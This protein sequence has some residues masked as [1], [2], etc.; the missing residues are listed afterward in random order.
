MNY[1]EFKE[2]N[3]PAL[4]K[5]MRQIKDVYV[6]MRD[7]K[8]LCVDIYLPDRDDRYPALLSFSLHNKELQ[9]SELCDTI[10]PQPAWSHFWYGNVEAGDTKYLVS[11]GY[12][13]V[14]A[15]AR[16]NGKSDS[17]TMFDAEMDHYD[18]IEWMAQQEWCDGNIGMLGLSA[19]AVNQLTAASEQPPHLKAIFPYDPGWCYG[20]FREMHLGGIINMLAY[21]LEHLSVAH[22]SVGQPP[23]LDE[24][25]EALWQKAM[26]NPDYMMYANIYNLLCQKGEYNPFG[27]LFQDLLYPYE[28]EG[29]MEMAQAKIDKIKIPVYTGSGQYAIDYHFHWQ[30]AQN[31]FKAL[32]NIP[33]KLQLGGPAHNERPFHSFHNEILKWYDYWLKG[34]DTGVMDEPPVRYWVT[35]ENKWRY[36][37]NWP[38]PETQWTKYYLHS[39]ERLRTDKIDSY[40]RDGYKEPDAFVQMSPTMT[41]EISLLRYMTEPLAEDTMIAGPISLNFFAALDSDDTTWIVTLKD[42]GPDYSDRT[43]REGERE[44]KE[45]PEKV[46]THGYL[47]ASMRE[48][49]KELS[50][51]EKPWHKLTKEAQKMVVPGEINEYN[52]EIMSVCHMFKSGHRISIEIACLDLP[53]GVAGATNVECIPYHICQNKT[54]YHKI[55]RDGKH[56]SHLLLPII[57]IKK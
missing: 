42:L 44:Q 43:G 47:R 49:D 36:A 15:Q 10:P 13:H 25:T 37:S 5:G 28:M 19:F 7:G 21:H 17:G 48:L 35:G 50:T 26:K 45:L 27:T 38:V 55:Y 24:E 23:K 54:V 52:I 34:I 4:Y 46:L 2:Y 1:K 18:I 12:A 53:T 20:V 33:K 3:P 41:N 30:G 8:K 40:A 14:I 39:W 6:P 22:R 32:K 11:R 57:P 51:P 16:G 31:W 29:Y 9:G 56:P